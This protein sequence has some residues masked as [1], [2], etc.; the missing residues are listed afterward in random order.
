[1]IGQIVKDED[2]PIGEDGKP[3]EILINPLGLIG[4]INP[5]QI[6]EA[7]LG[8]IAAKTGKA[9]KLRDFDTV[10]DLQDWAMQEL[11]DNGMSPTESITD[12]RTG[13]KINDVFTGNRWIMKLH[14]SAEGK[15]QSR[16]LGGYSSAGEPSGANDESDTAKRFGLLEVNAMLSHGSTKVLREASLVRGQANPKYWAE[17]M[18]G[19]TP[20]A[21]EI[22]F[23]YDKFVSQLQAAG[24][25]PI[26]NGSKVRLATMTDK[27]VDK[28]S[29]GRELKSAETVNWK[30]LEPIDG[31]LFDRAIFGGHAG[32]RWGFVQLPHP[33]PN[34]VMEEPI[35]RV[36]GLTK[37]KLNGVIAGKE[38]LNG[39]TGPQAIYSALSSINLNEAVDRA[40]MDAKSTRATTRDA[41]IRKL[42]YLKTVQEQGLHPKDWMVTKVPVIPPVFRPLGVMGNKKL[43]LVDDAN[44][45]L[46]ELID[47]NN[48]TKELSQHME[49]KDYGDELLATYNSMKAVSG[50]GDPIQAKNQERNVKGILKHIFGT[51]GPK[52]GTVQ[53]KLLGSTVDFVSRGTIVPQPELHMDQVGIPERAAWDMYRPMLV[54]RL[55]RQ[56]M[57][58]I[59]AAKTVQ[60]KLP[61]ARKALQEEM[62]SGVVLMNRAPSWHRYSV[63]G[64][65]PVMVKGDAIQV[66][67]LVV[68]GFGADF[69]GDA[70]NVHAVVT[71]A[72]KKEALAKMF[73]SKNL[74]DVA[75]FKVHQLPTKEFVAGLYEAS[76]QKDD[77]RPPML[78]ASPEDAMKA[79]RDG[80]VDLGRKVS[81]LMKD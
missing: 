62:E 21:P 12:V 9:Y 48:V 23:V 77:K 76:R 39:A 26:R 32:K 64:F 80:K 24:I 50:L 34:P 30:T 65:K 54:R 4:R 16:G 61:V 47:A 15:L 2:M 13:R 3:F 19:Y 29:G 69:D 71:E 35:R 44:Y 10:K 55:V 53:R 66:S 20:S 68:K 45:L 78:F 6:I 40:R 41:A 18:S 73:P 28:L 75:E 49:P 70:V 31:G 8:K 33:L 5:G 79:Y 60:E 14:H 51:N 1:M 17:F 27:D 22:P 52:T 42:G 25:N 56:G 11:S 7:S 46:K 36:L 63:M 74:L 58:R 38:E 37:N 57:P 43:P 67:P 72:A 81:V 59:E